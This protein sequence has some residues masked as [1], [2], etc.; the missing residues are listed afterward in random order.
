MVLLCQLQD[1]EKLI[2]P[3]KVEAVDTT[4][5]GDAF[6]GGFVTALSEGKTIEEAV[7]FANCVGAL[8]VQKIGTTPAMPERSQI[9]ELFQK[10]YK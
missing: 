6:N 3:I 10:I 2:S 5:A 9:D 4:G 1:G 7:K 8:S